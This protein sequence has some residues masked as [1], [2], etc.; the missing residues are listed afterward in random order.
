MKNLIAIFLIFLAGCSNEADSD[1]RYTTLLTGT[2]SSEYTYD[3]GAIK[4]YG[5][6]TYHQDG[7]A[8]GFISDQRLVADQYLEFRRQEYSSQW[9]IENGV[10]VITNVKFTPQIEDSDA[11]VIRDQIL[12]INAYQ[13]RFKAFSDGSTFIRYRVKDEP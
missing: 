11:V 10:V 5:E 4:S 6:K 13:A 1:K 2:W 9:K 7:S 12:E 8:T 3:D